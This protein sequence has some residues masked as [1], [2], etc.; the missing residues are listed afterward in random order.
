MRR[1]NSLEIVPGHTQNGGVA[2]RV[3]IV[4]AAVAVQ[5]GHIAKPNAGLDVGE[6]D[7][8]ARQ[9]GSADPNRALGAGDP[10][11]G[12]VPASGDQ[13]AVLESFDVSASKYVVP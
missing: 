11:F 1:Q 7:L 5:N 9:R 3:S 2:M 8:F 13:I 4:G 10:F 6:G 12:R